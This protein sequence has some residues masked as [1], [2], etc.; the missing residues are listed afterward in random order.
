MGQIG[1]GSVTARLVPT[2]VATLSNNVSSVAAGRYQSC[3]VLANGAWYCWGNNSYGLLGNGNT[4]DQHS[5]VAV[6]SLGSRIVALDSGYCHT[7]ATTVAGTTKC[8]GLNSNGQLGDNKQ[9][10]TSTITPVS[11]QF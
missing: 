10:G 1:D 8:W 3:A 11:V 9:S 4:A 5:P 6:Q 2:A 7:C